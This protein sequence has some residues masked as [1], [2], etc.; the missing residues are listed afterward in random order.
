MDRNT[1]N[2]EAPAGLVPF[3]LG[4][5]IVRT[6]VGVMESVCNV[7]FVTALRV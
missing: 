6:K 2:Q 5:G 3:A 1:A 7:L 4:V